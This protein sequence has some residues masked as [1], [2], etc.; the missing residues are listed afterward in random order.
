MIKIKNIKFRK[1]LNSAGKDATEIEILTDENILGIASTPSAI[2]SGKREVIT[3]SAIENKEKL[4]KE[5]L[6]KICNIELKNQSE[7]D[8]ILNEH[9]ERIGSNICLALSLAFARVYAKKEKISL[10]QYISNEANEKNNSLSPKPLVTIF[11]GGV[12]N[13]KD[14]IQNIMLSVNIH[15]FSEAVKAI[16]EIYTYIENELKEKNILKGY[17]ASSGM[18]V[19]DITTDEKFELVEHTI[20]KLNYQD[21]VSIAIDVAAEHFYENGKYIYEGKRVNSEQLYNIIMEYIQKYNITFVEDPFDSKDEE[22][23]KKFKKE[24]SNILT[25]GDDL[26]ATQSKYIN[27]ELANGMIVK[28]NQ[29]GTLTG[30]IDAAKKARDEKM[31]ICVSHRSIETEDTFI[32]DLAVALNADYIKIGGPRR[33]DRIAKYNRLLRLESEN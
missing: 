16:T 30:T 28:I 24:N 13:K 19:S 15:P 27:S 1:I 22:T 2:I 32:C 20:K 10:V 29:V 18:I 12:H 26:F 9:I 6:Q 4:I 5:L 21:K 8:M 7:F 17:G 11:S 33:G 31:S 23:W 14:S 3:E 25:V